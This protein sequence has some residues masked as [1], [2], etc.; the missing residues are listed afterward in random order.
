M[1]SGHLE[2]VRASLDE[3]VVQTLYDVVS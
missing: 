1:A 3:G 2:K